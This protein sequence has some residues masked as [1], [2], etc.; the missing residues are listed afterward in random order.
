MAEYEGILITSGLSEKN[1][2]DIIKILKMIYGDRIYSCPK[3]KYLRLKNEMD[4]VESSIS[5]GAY[6]FKTSF[7]CWCYD[8]H[9]EDFDDLKLYVEQIDSIERKLYEMVVLLDNKVHVITPREFILKNSM[10][11]H[12]VY[13]NNR[14]SVIKPTSADSYMFLCQFHREKTPSM[15]VNNSRNFLQC[16]GCGN[17]FDSIEYMMEYEDLSEDD[18]MS[19]LANVYCLNYPDKKEPIMDLQ[20]KYTKTLLS[21]EFRSLLEI[22]YNRTK[23]KKRTY[24]V[25]NGIAKFEQ[26]FETIKRVSE[27]R[28]KDY[29]LED[30]P[31]VYV[32]K[33]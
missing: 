10:L 2:K 11:T 33:E 6:P 4:E 16:F 7:D 8:R 29:I 23:L 26:D 24:F 30:K 9:K 25:K 17:I 14:H 13:S 12:L 5:K 3:E 1:R 31:K 32:K 21:D 15:L 27:G 20:D 22:G 18:A 28:D 19:V